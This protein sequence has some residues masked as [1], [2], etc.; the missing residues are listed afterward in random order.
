MEDPDEVRRREESDRDRPDRDDAGLEKMIVP[1]AIPPNEG[2]EEPIPDEP[3]RA[4]PP[5]RRD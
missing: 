1:L 4:D 3:E 2:D 5:T